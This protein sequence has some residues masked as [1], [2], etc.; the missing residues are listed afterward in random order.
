MLDGENIIIKKAKNGD[1]EAFGLLYDYYFE[2][3]YRFIYLKVS[4]K[5]D[6]EDLAHQVFL[7]ALKKMKDYEYKGLPFSSWLYKIARNEIVDF[8][9]SKKTNTTLEELENVLSSDDDIDIKDKLDLKIQL[10]KV[11][12][13]IKKI[14]PEYQDIIIMRFIEDLSIK[15]VAEILDKTEGSIKLMQHRAINSLKKILKI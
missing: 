14:K 12:E 4:H 7:Q 13:A 11:K 5:E 15:E 2:Q 6:A 1:A 3:I 9:R 10:E 8:Y